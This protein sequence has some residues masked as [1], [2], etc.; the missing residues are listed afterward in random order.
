VYR[1]RFG[2]RSHYKLRPFSPF[3]EVHWADCGQVYVT[4]VGAEDISVVFITGEQHL[5]LD[6]V[7]SAFPELA[8]QLKGVAP[9]DRATGGISGTRKLQAVTVGRIALLGDASGSADAITGDGLSL[10]F[11]QAIA[12]ADAMLTGDL[13]QY[14]DMHERISRLPR[15]MGE[16]M[17]L[18]D[19]HR[20]LRKRVFRAF[21]GS[22]EMF[23][24]LL[25]MHTQTLS[26]A[27]LGVKDC[28]SFGWNVL[29]A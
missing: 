3:V 6:Q 17:L 26:P 8:A 20:W 27:Q 4:P 11:R 28:L 1:R 16:L 9:S 5:R 19:D 25:A 18:M 12:L 10:L 23:G 29:R 14:Q 22:P 7:L 21:S 13:G 15:T 2:F 24:K